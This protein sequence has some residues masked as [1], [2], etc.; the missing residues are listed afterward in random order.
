MRSTC[1][2][3]ASFQMFLSK[4]IFLNFIDHTFTC[5]AAGE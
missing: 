5:A 3:Q 4:K 2:L 1:Y